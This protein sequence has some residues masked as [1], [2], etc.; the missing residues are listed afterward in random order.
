MQIILLAIEVDLELS[1]YQLIQTS[2]GTFF[3]SAAKS[4]LLD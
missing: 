4:G 3:E 1:C 2:Q